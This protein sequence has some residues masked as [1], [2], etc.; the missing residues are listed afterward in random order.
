MGIL[1]KLKPKK[2]N[3]HNP[4]DEA[5][6][7]HDGVDSNADNQITESEPT[8]YE[9]VGDE[10]V[11]LGIPQNTS[12]NKKSNVQKVGFLVV[13]LVGLGVVVAGL[14]SFMGGSSEDDSSKETEQLDV[15]VKNSQ[16]KDFSQ[17]KEAL[18]LM[19][20]EE[21]EDAAASDAMASDMGNAD[22]ATN[23]TNQVPA[24]DGSSQSMEYAST[25][26][27]GQ[28]QSNSE[29]GMTPR[30]RK[31]T[32]DV[33]VNTGNKDMGGGSGNDEA[34]YHMT[35]NT[36]NNSGDSD[37]FI[38]NNGGDKGSF[39]SRLKPS[40]TMNATAIKRGDV[41][42][43]LRK[44][45]NIPCTLDTQIIT[46]H[47]GLTRCVVSKDV[48]SANGKVLLLERGSVVNG[49]Q[50]A[51]LVQGQARVFV[52]WNDVETPKGIKVA[53]NSPSAGQLG[54]SGQAAHVKYHFFRRFGGAILIS[55]IGDFG[56]AYSNRQKGNNQ[57][58]TFETTSESAQDMA[59]EALKNSIN[60]PPTGYINQGQLLNIMVARDVDF[61][62]VYEVVDTRL[63]Y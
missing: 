29:T 42:Y 58:I 52:L 30:H 48:Y 63:M 7:L 46:T 27:S 40:T 24:P 37:T 43:L 13:G 56:T 4:L 31:M 26:P 25:S 9:K 36:G 11:E 10:T 19:A 2:P 47:A 45:T 39:A 14:M 15:G 8:M 23:S 18:A 35:G 53:L 32:G 38:A 61:G 34:N 20:E 57:N 55:M 59:T 16:H 1:N 62:K 28:S 21:A 41:T 54:A 5:Q 51:A 44:G 6:A 49:E 22:M 50:T 12:T 60:I 3:G 33:L 17:D